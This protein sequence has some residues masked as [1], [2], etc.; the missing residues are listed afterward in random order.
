[1]NISALDH[2][3]SAAKG[4]LLG[5]PLSLQVKLSHLDKPN[6]I[7]ERHKANCQVIHASLANESSSVR[8]FDLVSD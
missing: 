4:R 2:V 7:S 5:Y 8:V 3:T 6:L 1:M